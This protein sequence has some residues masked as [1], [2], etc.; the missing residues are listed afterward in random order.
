MLRV[1]LQGHEGHDVSVLFPFSGRSSPSANDAAY[2]SD[3]YL[4]EAYQ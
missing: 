1:S 3:S 2:C 4:V